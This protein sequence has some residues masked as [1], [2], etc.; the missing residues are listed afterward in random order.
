[1][2]KYIYQA[3]GIFYNNEKKLE[4]EELTDDIM[5]T[6][7]SDH[8][9]IIEISRYQTLSVYKYSDEEEKQLLTTKL[10]AKPYPQKIMAEIDLSD[11][12]ITGIEKIKAEYTGNPIFSLSFDG[13][14]TWQ[15]H[16]GDQWVKISMETSGMQAETMQD[17]QPEQWKEQIVEVASI[18][19]CSILTE[20][21]DSISSIVVNFT[22]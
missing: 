11:S 5:Q 4:I 16:D 20:E 14:K 2:N 9:S 19:L 17:I 10:H 15:I 8:L 1:M 3:D 6:Q 18:W 13:K 12:T 7:G 21:K 22:N